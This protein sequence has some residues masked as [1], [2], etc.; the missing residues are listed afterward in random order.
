MAKKR[1]TTKKTTTKSRA[2]TAAKRVSSKA[3]SRAASAKRKSSSAAKRARIVSKSSKPATKISRSAQQSLATWQLAFVAGV[4]FIAAYIFA[5]L[6]IDSG[7]YWHYLLCIISS[8]FG[9]KFMVKTV[10]SLL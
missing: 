7:S 10:R 5:S 2:K 6:A 9:V 3:N 4:G 1:K 8:Y